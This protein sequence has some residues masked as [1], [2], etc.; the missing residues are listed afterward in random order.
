MIDNIE[1]QFT[2]AMPTKESIRDILNSIKNF[3]INWTE[4]FVWSSSFPDDTKD[5]QI[6]EDAING[7]INNIEEED[8]FIYSER[9]LGEHS[10]HALLMKH[11]NDEQLYVQFVCEEPNFTL[12]QFHYYEQFFYNIYQSLDS[13]IFYKSFV[14]VASKRKFYREN[15]L[16][17]I[18]FYTDPFLEEDFCYRC[19]TPK[20]V[21]G[22]WHTKEQLLQAPFYSIK[23]LANETLEIIQ[24]EHPIDITNTQH[25]E[26]MRSLQTYLSEHNTYPE[27]L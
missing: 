1:I 16:M 23:E 4:I 21:Y 22:K 24:F 9:K 14:G 20:S 3:N 18:N 13:K 5:Y 12:E 26:N 27:D 8:S 25:I 17:D 6:F 11:I 10:K 7:F 19:L 15:D 2:V